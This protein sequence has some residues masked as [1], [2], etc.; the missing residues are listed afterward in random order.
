MARGV[1]G[2]DLRSI[3]DSSPIP[4]LYDMDSVEATGGEASDIGNE[5]GDVDT[6][7][8]PEMHQEIMSLIEEIGPEIVLKALQGL[9]K[10]V[11]PEPEGMGPPGGEMPTMAA[12]GALM[13][14]GQ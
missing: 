5:G 6:S 13:G 2:T 9:A 11:S 14:L 1:P 3:P 8:T 4:A 7:M 12:P 10:K